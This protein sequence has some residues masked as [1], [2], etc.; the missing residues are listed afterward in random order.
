L[1]VD[2]Q[3]FKPNFRESG[4][5]KELFSS[6]SMLQE[7]QRARWAQFDV[8]KYGRPLA[9]VQ[10]AIESGKLVADSVDRGGLRLTHVA[11]AYNRVDILEWLLAVKEMDL[12]DIDD[13]YRS[14]LDVAKASK[15]VAAGTW[16]RERKAREVLSGFVGKYWRRHLAIIRKDRMISAAT[17]LQA[18]LRGRLARKSFRGK[19]L[20]R[21]DESQRFRTV[22]GPALELL[23]RVRVDTPSWASI[24]S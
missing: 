3:K 12:N 8:I 7:K 1:H 6:I 4:A 10:A 2:I 22:W 13:Q 16:I 18:L 19:L 24:R 20:M 17:I 21:I 5:R 9:E 11:A 23:S 14:I 15:A